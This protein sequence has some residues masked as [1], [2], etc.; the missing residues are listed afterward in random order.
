MP[1]QTY[2]MPRQSLNLLRQILNLSGWA[3][4]VT[5]FYLAGKLLSELPEVDL[6][7]VLTT[8]DIARLPRDERAAYVLKDKNYG[9]EQIEFTLDDK[10]RELIRKALEANFNRLSPDIFT[11]T[12]FNC[13]G[14][15]P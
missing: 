5:E 10:G 11:W 2:K 1:E 7:W 15:A 13:F 12:L 6:S 8:D 4:T 9:K 14:F 3:K